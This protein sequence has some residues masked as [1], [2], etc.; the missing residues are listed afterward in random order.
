MT[1]QEQVQLLPCPACGPDGHPE[2]HG[3][4]SRGG[5]YVRC[6]ICGFHGPVNY[7]QAKAIAAWNTRHMDEVTKIP[8]ALLDQSC[9]IG[10]IG[11]NVV[12][13]CETRAEAEEVLDWLCDARPALTAAIAKIEGEQP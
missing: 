9:C 6:E 10:L 2:L 3:S 7:G 4:I 12:I 1:E 11:K 13:D 8:S 5:R